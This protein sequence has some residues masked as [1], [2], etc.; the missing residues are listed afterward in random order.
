MPVGSLPRIAELTGAKF[1]HAETAGELEQVY[2]EIEQL[3]RT[4]REELSFAEHFDLYPRLLVPAFLLYLFGW[5]FALTW[6][7]RLP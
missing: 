4:E 3:E 5:L 2:A 6:A 1:F 7:R